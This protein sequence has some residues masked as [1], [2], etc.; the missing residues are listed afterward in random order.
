MDKK[1]AVFSNS[2]AGTA[3]FGSLSDE[4]ISHYQ[5]NS[6]HKDEREAREA[7]RAYNKKAAQEADELHAAEWD[8]FHK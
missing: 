6:I 5:I 8:R 2:A 4:P 3:Y 7:A 1:Y